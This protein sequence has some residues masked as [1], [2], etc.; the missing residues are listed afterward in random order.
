VRHLFIINPNSFD[1][2]ETMENVI[3]EINDCF[4]EDGEYKIHISRYSRDA[5]AVIHHYIEALTPDITVRVYA[6]GGDGILFDCL[7]GMVHFPNAEITNVPYG[8][9]NDFIRAFGEE[10]KSKFLEIKDL[11]H[12][13]ARPVDVIN[14]GSNYTVNQVGIGLEGQS[15]IDAGHFIHARGFKWLKRFVGQIYT[16]ATFGTLFNKEVMQQKYHIVLDGADISGPYFNIKVSNGPCSG[17]NMI[18]NPHSKPDSGFLDGIFAVP[19]PLFTILAAVKDFTNGRFEKHKILSH[20]QFKKMELASDA[21]IRVHLDGE[22]FYTDKLTIEILPGGI[23]FFAPEG[24][25]FYDYANN[26]NIK[27]AKP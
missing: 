21:P 12:A 7:N 1:A 25:W 24:L 14:C 2:P 20:K 22:A 18:S 9:S 26:M 19:A 16:I 3:H 17:G 23:R 6:V 11:I 4:T 5:I 8:K 13:P 10:A 27:R 15:A